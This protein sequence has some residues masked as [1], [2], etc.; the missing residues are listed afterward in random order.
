MKNNLARD[1]GG[2]IFYLEKEEIQFLQST[3]KSINILSNMDLNIGLDAQTKTSIHDEMWRNVIAEYDANNLSNYLRSNSFNS[4]PEFSMLWRIWLH[5]EN[6]HYIGLRRIYCSIY[7]KCEKE[8]HKEVI[9]RIPVFMEISHFLKDEFTLCVCLAYDELASA[10]GYGDAFELYD[11]FGY[12]CISQWIRLTANDEMNHAIN[13]R[14]LLSTNYKHRLNEVPDI[15]QRVVKEEHINPDDYKAT[16][17][18]DHGDDQGNN[19]FT[20][21]FLKKCA[22]DTCSFLSVP[23]AFEEM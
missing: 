18:F 21:D 2:E 3:W 23:L 7:N 4:S 11:S 14:T 19:P 1:I 16:F 9:S 15:L 12:P 6:N 8:V 20:R 13:A 17:L 5:D 22:N 10:R